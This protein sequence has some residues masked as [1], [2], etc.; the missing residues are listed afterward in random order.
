[1]HIFTQKPG[2]I[3]YCG[4]INNSS[5][6]LFRGQGEHLPTDKNERNLT[7]SNMKMLINFFLGGNI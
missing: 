1:M 5:F 7:I 6:Q 2:Y 3:V 4:K